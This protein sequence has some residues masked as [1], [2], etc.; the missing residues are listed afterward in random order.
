MAANSSAT[1]RG[2]TT[3]TVSKWPRSKYRWCAACDGER[4]LVNDVDQLM[5]IRQRL[6]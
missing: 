4:L 2:T 3:A 6:L 5:A 1:C